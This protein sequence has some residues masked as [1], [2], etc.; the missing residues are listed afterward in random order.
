MALT[1][2]SVAILP[3]EAAE[4]GYDAYYNTMAEA[5][6]LEDGDLTTGDGTHLTMN[7]IES[8]GTWSAAPDTTAVTWD[9]WT[10]NYAA[11]QY[12]TVQTVGGARSSNGLWDTTAYIQS[13]TDAR[14]Q[15]IDNDFST[16]NLAIEFIGVQFYQATIDLYTMETNSGSYLEY[17]GFEKCYIK[18]DV[19][20]RVAIYCE[21][22]A[23]YTVVVKNCVIECTNASPS[24]RGINCTLATPT[25]YIY[26]NTIFGF[27]NA[28]R[29]SSGYVVNNAIFDNDDEDTEN[30]GGYNLLDYCATDDASEGTNV[31]DISPAAEADG[32]AAAFNAYAASQD[33]TVTSTD[34]P[35]YLAGQNQTADSEVP[36]DDIT[37]YT[38]P[39]AANPVTIGAFEYVTAATTTTTT[40]TT[41]STTTTTT[42]TT[43]TST[44]TTT[45][46][47]TTTTTSTT[48]TSTTT[49]TTS[50]TTT[51]T[52][53]TTTSTT[54]TTTSTT[55]TTTSTTTTTTST[56]TT[57][58]T[59]S[60]TTTTTSTTTTTTSTTTTT[61]STT[62]TTGAGLATD[63]LHIFS[64]TNI[65]PN[66]ASDNLSSVLIGGDLEVQGNIYGGTVNADDGA[67]FNGAITNLTIVN[68]IVT[69]AS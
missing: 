18:T 44:T 62:T 15:L 7:I 64:E 28:L 29:L 55:T 23:A 69:A 50:T 67:N 52:S 4:A 47:T 43:T 54:T 40:T 68:G 56:S 38:R 19:A 58:T 30:F 14:C 32:W 63:Y 48:T 65:E 20:G 1:E 51:T 6:D 36:A 35:L 22:D 25:L 61:T 16:T 33:V 5:E 42:S 53:T 2:R 46:S 66:H 21:L 17:L 45:T 39:L 11:E 8:D 49:T 59:T 24:N 27:N 3:A 57:T 31:V 41:T 13:V 37:G 60:T 10:C 12:I 34:S 26:N 9:G